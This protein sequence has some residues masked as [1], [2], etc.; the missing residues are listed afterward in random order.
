MERGWIGGD[1]CVDGGDGRMLKMGMVKCQNDE[2]VV[3]GDGG[4]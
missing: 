3:G 4:W 2:C 1:E